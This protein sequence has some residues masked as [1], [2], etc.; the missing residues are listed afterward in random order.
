MYPGVST[1]L[2]GCNHRYKTLGHDPL[3]GLIVGTSNIATSTLCVNDFASLFP[4]YRIKNK[5]ID[6]YTNIF[7]ILNETYSIFNEKKQ[8]KIT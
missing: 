6:E 1:G 8:S 5:E 4:S 3:V 2:S 7:T